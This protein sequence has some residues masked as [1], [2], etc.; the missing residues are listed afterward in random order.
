MGAIGE[1]WKTDTGLAVAGALVGGPVGLLASLAFIY[2]QYK[3]KGGEPLVPFQNPA[4]PSEVIVFDPHPELKPPNNPAMPPG[5]SRLPQAV[6]NRPEV[7]SWFVKVLNDSKTYP[8]YSTVTKQIDDM[9]VMI[10]VEWHTWTHRQGEL[11]TG[12]FRGTTGYIVP[13]GTITGGA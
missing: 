9:I 4:D 10:R 13:P 2:S 1:D 12:L 5:V 6:G 11:V 8:M 3:G 7:S